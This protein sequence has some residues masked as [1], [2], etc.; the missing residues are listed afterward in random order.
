MFVRSR[1]QTMDFQPI[2]KI[3]ITDPPKLTQ[4]QMTSVFRADPFAVNNGPTNTIS[5]TFINGHHGP[6]LHPPI[7]FE[8]SLFDISSS[9]PV[10]AST[11]SPNIL[12]PTLKRTRTISATTPTSPSSFLFTPP[13]LPFPPQIPSILYPFLGLSSNDPSWS[14]TADNSLPFIQKSNHWMPTSL[15]GRKNSFLPNHPTSN[16]GFHKE[17]T[18]TPLPPLLALFANFGRSGQPLPTDERKLLSEW[19]YHPC[20]VSSF[21]YLSSK[22]LT[23]PSNQWQGLPGPNLVTVS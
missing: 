23:I 19:P 21:S 3:E 20:E 2:L 8:Y 16:L 17:R 6:L 14:I 13:T 4:S 18:N 1:G 11:L 22:L 5:E 7:I 15:S 10:P 9:S 12:Q